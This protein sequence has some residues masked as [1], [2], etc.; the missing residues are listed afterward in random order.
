MTST[1]VNERGQYSALMESQG[2]YT[3]NLT[4]W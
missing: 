2:N 1:A 4:K 3:D